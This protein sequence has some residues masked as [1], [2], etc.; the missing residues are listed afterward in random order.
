MRQECNGF[1]AKKVRLEGIN[2]YATPKL[3][4]GQGKLSFLT[5]KCVFSFSILL[6][7]A[8][9]SCMKKSDQ[10]QQAIR[11]RDT[12][13][14]IKELRDSISGSL[15][16]SKGIASQKKTSSDTTLQKKGSMLVDTLVGSVYVSGNEPF[17]RL[18]L[19]LKDGG[20]NIF[21]Q[22]DTTQ[23]KQLRKLQGRVVKIFG[24]IVKSGTGDYVRVNEF[25][26]VQ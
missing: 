6:I 8:L 4:P 2:S 1:F 17:T 24:P 23:S 19:A 18:T 16:I 5:T 12:V 11:E 10:R 13:A 20:S 21:I 15:L 3:P 26:I 25:V 14:G 9:P 22:A 7:L